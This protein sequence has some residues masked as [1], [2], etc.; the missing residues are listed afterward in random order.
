VRIPLSKSVE[1]PISSVA[2]F[3]ICAIR[4]ALAVIRYSKRLEAGMA[5]RRSVAPAGMPG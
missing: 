5:G 2:A 1:V 3:D 4:H